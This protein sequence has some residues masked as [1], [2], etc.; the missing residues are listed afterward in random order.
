MTTEPAPALAGDTP[1]TRGAPGPEAGEV[2]VVLEEE[3][4]LEE[5]LE[6]ALEAD[7]EVAVLGGAGRVLGGSVD[8][9]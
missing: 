1:V 8:T 2:V 5:V 6:E 4:V 3:E 7:S 9:P